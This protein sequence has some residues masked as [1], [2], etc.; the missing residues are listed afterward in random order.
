MHKQTLV[1]GENMIPYY[2]FTSL[3][4]FYKI[5]ATGKLILTKC[6]SLK[7]VTIETMALEATLKNLLK[8]EREFLY[9]KFGCNNDQDVIN[10]NM[11]YREKSYMI[12]FSK[13]KNENIAIQ[14]DYLW[15]YYADNNQGVI[16][17]FDYTKFPYKS[18]GSQSING[19][20][21]SEFRI[22]HMLYEEETFKN[23]IK[24]K[25]DYLDVLYLDSYKPNFCSLENEIRFIVFLKEP[26]D[27]GTTNLMHKVS[28]HD[29]R[30]ITAQEYSGNR[31][32]Y[33]LYDII[34]KEGNETAI[35]KVFCKDKETYNRLKQ[36][37]NNNILIDLL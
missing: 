36:I 33:L 24:E 5:L 3:E 23:K 21:I 10:K 17:K 4:N 15:K 29:I 14:N 13:D 35:E 1:W 25:E 26:S 11:N 19:E 34:S 9:E 12:C 30:R 16:I 22:L 20:R 8:T 31:P 6:N 37:L 32:Q 18:H 27:L 28:N 7:N 2:H